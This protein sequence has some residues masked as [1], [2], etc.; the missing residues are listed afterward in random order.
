VDV[1]RVRGHEREDESTRRLFTTA[2]ADRSNAVP[3]HSQIFP[4]LT[5][6][7]GLYNK[8]ATIRAQGGIFI[9]TQ[10]GKAATKKN[11]EY[12]AQSPQRAP[13]LKDQIDLGSGLRGLCGL[14]VLGASKSYVSDRCGCE[15][16]A[17][18]A[19]RGR[20][21]VKIS[22]QLANNFH[23]SSTRW[24]FRKVFFGVYFV[25]RFGTEAIT[26]R[27]FHSWALSPRA[28]RAVLPPQGA[29]GNWQTARCK[30]AKTSLT[31][32]QPGSALPRFENSRNV[33]TSGEMAAIT[34]RCIV[35][36]R[37]ESPTARPGRRIGAERRQYFH[38]RILRRN[39]C[40]L[41]RELL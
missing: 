31:H 39:C 32:L 27:P 3:Y 22:S 9:E 29:R 13:S 24:R 12:L 26:T 19:D 37:P 36:L 20:L 17:R 2:R 34:D 7:E 18:Q 21:I 16:I 4:Q 23:C 8:G 1:V 10:R 30:F 38:Q 6:L 11:G 5:V 35:G 41:E 40:R 28:C 15:H 14:G 33:E 25:F